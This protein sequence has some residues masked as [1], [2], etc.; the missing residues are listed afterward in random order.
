MEN[1]N[2]QTMPS[3]YDHYV[4]KIL[5][6]NFTPAKNDQIWV[7]DKSDDRRY[8]NH[9]NRVAGE[10]GFNAIENARVTFEPILSKAEGCWAEIIKEILTRRTL[11]CLDESKRSEFAHF[12][13]VQFFRTKEHRLRHVDLT[14]GLRDELRRRGATEEEIAVL[15]KN[16]SEIPEEKLFGFLDV[17]NARRFIPHFL[18][19]R[20]VLYE[21]NAQSPFFISDNPV[22]LHNE[23]TLGPYGNIGLGVKGI[24]IYL[25]LSTTLCIAF[26]CPS[27]TYEYEKSILLNK[28]IEQKG[29]ANQVPDY[30]QVRAFCEGL[31]NG[32]PIRVSE[33]SVTMMNSLQVT[34]SSRFVYCETNSFELVERMIREDQKYRSALRPTIDAP[35]GRRER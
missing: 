35:R 30:P 18:D 8:S 10:R 6:R 5:L 12:I 14:S 17:V 24:E 26:L 15:T 9:I 13:A 7:Y 1:L 11:S 27:I 4:P 3:S 19:K 25:P 28:M 23:Q 31:A 34:Y 2:N 20:W 29:L 32:N 22:T 16:P 21:T 33:E